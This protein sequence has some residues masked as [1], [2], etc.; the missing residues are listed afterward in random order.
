[1]SPLL[2]SPLPLWC[3]LISSSLSCSSLLPATSPK[4]ALRLFSSAK[5]CL[6]HCSLKKCPTPW[7]SGSCLLL[8][9]SCLSPAGTPASVAFFQFFCYTWPTPIL[10]PC[11]CSGTFSPTVQLSLS[12]D[13]PVNAPAFSE[14]SIDTIT[15][16]KSSLSIH[17][18]S[19]FS[20]YTL[21][22]LLP[23]L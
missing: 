13:M 18:R 8:Q 2:S 11:S 10:V 12:H 16:G 20:L 14:L 7:P 3:K 1:M 19:A 5:T 9:L 22:A 15:S 23:F 6:S 4:A 21:I 17:Y